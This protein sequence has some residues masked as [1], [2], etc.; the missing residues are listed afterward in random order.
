LSLA[1]AALNPAAEVF[2]VDNDPDTL[3]VAEANAAANGLA[4]R[5]K[6]SVTTG[7]E[8]EETAA[9]KDLAPPFDLMAANL[10]LAP[11]L[12]LAPRLTSLA[13]PA[14]R[15]ILSGLLDNQASAAASAYEVLGWT[16]EA[17]LQR[18]EWAALV[19]NRAG[20]PA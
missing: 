7:T 3:A 14:G 8:A 16:L 10:T 1:A 11:L 18:E 17:S 19:L 2:G 15:L 13:G 5:I 9:L 12:E 20:G 6:F 4:G